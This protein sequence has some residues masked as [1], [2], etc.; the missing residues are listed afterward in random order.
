MHPERMEGH[1]GSEKFFIHIQVPWTRLS[2]T[3]TALLVCSMYLQI[4]GVS[5][6]TVSSM[7]SEQ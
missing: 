1:T 7:S 2:K 4:R 6:G 5:V 3:A